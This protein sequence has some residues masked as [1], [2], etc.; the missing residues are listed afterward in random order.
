MILRVKISTPSCLTKN[1]NISTSII[2]IF[3]FDNEFGRKRV[4]RK[5][6]KKKDSKRIEAGVLSKEE[7]SDSS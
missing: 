4:N 5:G 1:Q 3:G 7:F 2:C 6:D